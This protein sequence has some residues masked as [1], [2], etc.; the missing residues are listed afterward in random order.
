MTVRV[1][2]DLETT[3][4]ISLSTASRSLAAMLD[5]DATANTV[6]LIPSA[7]LSVVVF[8]AACPKTSPVNSTSAATALKRYFLIFIVRF[9][10]R[11]RVRVGFSLVLAVLRLFWLWLG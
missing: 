10:F 4:M 2:D 11:F 6:S 8:V 9:T 7:A 3:F 5:A 1:L